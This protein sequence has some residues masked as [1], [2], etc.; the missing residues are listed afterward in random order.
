MEH[1]Q[2]Q[3][4]R[5]YTFGPYNSGDSVSFTVETGDVNCDSSVDLHT[6]PPTGA[7]CVDPL[8]IDSLPYNTS[9]DTLI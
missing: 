8:L 3:F 4:K 2:F 6:C 1:Q 9:D 7:A 5:I